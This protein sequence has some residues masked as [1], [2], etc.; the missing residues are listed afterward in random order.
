MRS[1]LVRALVC[2]R[3]RVLVAAYVLVIVATGVAQL[4][5]QTLAGGWGHM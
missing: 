2:L 3:V 5:A 4:E 1:E